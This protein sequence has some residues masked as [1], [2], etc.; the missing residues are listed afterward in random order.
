MFVQYFYLFEKLFIFSQP[1][2]KP[3]QRVHRFCVVLKD[4]DNLFWNYR[5]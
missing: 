2:R 4:F 3:E 5:Q 1:P